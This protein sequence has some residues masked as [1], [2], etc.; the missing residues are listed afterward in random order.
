MVYGD[1]TGG[2]QGTAK[3]E[4]SDWELIERELFAHFGS[5]R[6]YMRVPR[7]NPP[8][9]SRVNALNTRLL[10][11]AGDIALMVDP[12]KAPNVIRDLEG[13]R[14]LEGGSGELDKKH[15]KT[16][17]HISDALGYYVVDEFPIE[18]E[19]TGSMDIRDIG[20]R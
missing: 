11:G 16:L 15:D 8:E 5:Q 19:R 6:V 3:V 10:N 7:H 1:A 13:V 4:G 17:T 18:G 2:A 20:L 9:R 12:S 14:V